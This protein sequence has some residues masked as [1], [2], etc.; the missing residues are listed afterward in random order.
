MRHFIRWVFGL[1]LIAAA[2]LCMFMAWL[3]GTA[4]SAEELP[5]LK[6]GDIV[7]QDSGG[8]QGLAIMLASHSLYT[9]TGL[10]ELA[11]DGTPMVVEAAGPVRTVPLKYWINNGAANRI[12]IK[13]IK[14]LSESDARMAIAR[15][16]TY[17]GVPYDIFFLNTRDAIYCS[18]L[19]YAAFKEGPKITVGR[20]EKVRELHFDNAA[21]RHLIEARWQKHP[22]C[23]SKDIATFEACYN[24]ILEQTLVTPASIARDPKM[25]LVYSNFGIAGD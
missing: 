24:V 19:I 21:V 20:E 16:H 4:V 22:L 6:T 9:H 1:L 15:A 8:G 18:E 11:A 25:E 14:G 12:T 5:A 23:Q 3:S 7:F 17:D 10:I 2:S 13:R